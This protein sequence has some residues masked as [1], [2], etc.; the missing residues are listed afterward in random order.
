MVDG[1]HDFTVADHQRNHSE[2]LIVS[3]IAGSLSD[4]S[5]FH[6]TFS[7]HIFLVYPNHDF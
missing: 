2:Q 6:F 4:I 5:H 1:I 3:W 7:F